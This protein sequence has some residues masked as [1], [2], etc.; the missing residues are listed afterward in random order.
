[1]NFALTESQSGSDMIK[2][3]SRAK[4]NTDGNWTISGSKARVS[5]ATEAGIY[6]TLFVTS[7]APRHKHMAMI[8]ISADA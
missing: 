4:I 8:A 5:L 1:M 6:F 7:D 2:M 3:Y